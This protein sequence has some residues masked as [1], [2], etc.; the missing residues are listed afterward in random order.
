MYTQVE[1]CGYIHQLFT[2]SDTLDTQASQTNKL[3]Q[4]Q[5]QTPKILVSIKAVCVHLC[6]FCS[7]LKVSKRKTFFLSTCQTV[8]IAT[9]KSRMSPS[10][11]L[12]NFLLIG[13]GRQ[14]CST[15]QR[16]EQYQ[17]VATQTIHDGGILF[18]IVQG[19]G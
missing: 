18:L 17:A 14:R 3:L 2:F 9:K 5:T 4:T 11:M 1:Q 19:N 10:K 12:Q 7:L 6:T 13:F 15:A 16:H 8:L